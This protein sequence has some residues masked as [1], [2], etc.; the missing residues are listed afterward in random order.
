MLPDYAFRIPKDDNDFWYTDYMDTEETQR[1]LHFQN[2]S[3]EDYLE[4]V[5]KDAC[6]AQLSK[7]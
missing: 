5:K 1:L 2:H 4:G 3:F 6:L 7:G